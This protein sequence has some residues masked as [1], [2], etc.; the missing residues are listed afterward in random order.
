MNNVNT[1][2]KENL[3][4]VSK[5]VFVAPGIPEKKLNNVAKAFNVADNL[6][7]VLAIYD[8]TVFGS[9]KDGIVFTGEKLVIKETFES[10]YDVFYNNIEAVEYIEDV[11]VNDK[12]KEKRTE[13]VSLMLKSGEVKQLKSLMECNYKK[14]SDVLEHTISD[15]DEFKEED[16]LITLAE[17]SEALKV[18]YVKIIVNMAFSDDDQV[19]KKEFAEILLLMTRLEL[20]TESRFTLRS[21][22]GAESSLIPVEELITII[23]R[24]C[25]PSHNKSIKISLVKDLISIFMSVN[26]GEYKNFP[27]LQ[28]VQPLLGVTDEEI[29]LAMM[30][31]Q[32]DYKMLRE[33]FSDDALKRS[34]KELTAK[35][36]AVGV[37]LAAVY[38]SGSVIGMSAAGITSGLATL[39][40]GGVLGFSSMATGIGVAVLIGVGAYKGIRHL[41]GANELDKTKRRELMLNEVI[42]Q[43]QSTLSALI[44]DLNYISGK[45][46]D[47][48]DA[49]NR[50][51]EKIQKLQKMMNALTGAA[52][53]L[54][55]KSNKMQ[56]SALKIK[57]PVY[58]DEAKL[59]SLTREPIKKQFHDIV[60]SFYEE[61]IV[62]EQHDGKSVE[63]KK[64][65]IKE[66]ASTQQLEK[67]AAIFEGIGYFRAGDVIKGKLTGLFS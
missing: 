34:M 65:K 12:G 57:C 32:Q 13:S 50:Q 3:P 23:D 9:A 15:F 14:L 38:L 42:K 21:Y 48:L 19:D 67:L 66:K 39:G 22:I 58:L 46:N 63:V 52:D 8:N 40:L 25:V 60:L 49:H 35:A 45:F 20:T 41:T 53:E 10:P 4:L 18:A 6:N 51:G 28:Q 5:N 31:I 16:Q 54:N 55:K 27:F 30:V 59:I 47:A 44:N 1:F 24:E 26:N 64:L 11:T 36:G 33:D 43:T 17:M 29:E 56:K 2:L 61:C 62:E 7:A 37:P